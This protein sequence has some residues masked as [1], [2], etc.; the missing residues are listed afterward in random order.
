MKYLLSLICLT[1]MLR[2]SAQTESVHLQLDKAI[3]Y[4]LDTIW[5]RG[6]V[7][8]N[9]TISNNSNNLYLELY[10]DSNK[11]IT[12]KIFPIFDGTCQ[13]QIITPFK[14]GLYWLRAYTLNSSD[15]LQSITV[16]GK[17]DHIVIRKLSANMKDLAVSAVSGLTISAR[18][19]DSNISCF[20]SPDDTS[21][22]NNQPLSLTV[23]HFGDTIATSTFFLNKDRIHKVNIDLH[24]LHG[25]VSLFF[26]HND[27]TIAKQDIFVPQKKIPIYL[28]HDS[29]HY[30]IQIHDSLPCT[31]SIT[32]VRSDIP[33]TSPPINQA[34]TPPGSNHFADTTNL[35]YQIKVKAN[36][37]NKSNLLLEPI[38][39]F[40]LKD[41]QAAFRMLKPDT[42][43]T[44]KLNR[45]FFYD[46]AYI[47]AS[48]NFSKNLSLQIT[49]IP[50][51][52]FHAPD[53]DQ[54][55]LD[56]I[57]IPFS[58]T[59]VSDTT[60]YKYLPEIK[61]KTSVSWADRNKILDEKYT[62]GRFSMPSHFN[63]DLR[64]EA[65]TKYSFN[66]FDFLQ[67]ECP[68]FT[69][70]P[71]GSGPPQ[72]KGKPVIFYLDEEIVNWR[73]LY[74]YNAS[75]FA[76]IKVIEDFVDDDRFIR[77]VSDIG[78]DVFASLKNPTG[79]DNSPSAM[80]CIYQRKGADFHYSPAE[81][82]LKVY[83]LKGYD[84]PMTW[85]TPDRTTL[86]WVP[87]TRSKIYHFNLPQKGASFFR[88]ILEGVNQNGEVLYLNEVVH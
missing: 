14:Q 68:L 18:C 5:I 37:K 57:N 73:Q 10:N 32:I 51:P 45:L 11:L 53:S 46:T 35:F 86:L 15:Y 84:K 85:T 12:R 27:T 72:F 54:F 9:A 3:A 44:Y 29:S 25:Y 19:T 55:E 60:H 74:S 31:Y 66:V 26:S 80:I 30:T 67:R 24:N 36:R 8:Q 6:F 41:S 83:P 21:I 20:L 81:S 61:I 23:L 1:V 40:I 77:Q 38:V 43:G 62:T 49:T 17:T 47:H 16:R 71:T 69:I 82:D 65:A 75:N 4:P 63:Y 59:P 76:Y 39:F 64:D 78:A 34:L 48:S 28:T 79:V 7:S 70:D 58:T 42:D 56:T 52:T 13:G 33:E 50:L 2:T 88:V 22:F 87:F